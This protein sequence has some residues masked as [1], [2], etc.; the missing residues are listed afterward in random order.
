MYIIIAR[1]IFFLRVVSRIY[2]YPNDMVGFQYEI[3][4][5]ANLFTYRGDCNTVLTIYELT[6]FSWQSCTHLICLSFYLAV[7][8]HISL[9]TQLYLRSPAARI[10]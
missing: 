4:A 2:I 6:K 1:S 7:G 9:Y 8:R 3:T 5:E 10:K